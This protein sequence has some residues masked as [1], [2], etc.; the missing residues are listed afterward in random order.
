MRVAW[1]WWHKLSKLTYFNFFRQIWFL[2]IVKFA[3]FAGFEKVPHTTHQ[4]LTLS[5]T[6][7]TT[8]YFD[9]TL[10][11]SQLHL[12]NKYRE[13][14]E[15]LFS[16]LRTLNSTFTSS[17]KNSDM[18]QLSRNILITNFVRF[19]FNFLSINHCQDQSFLI[20]IFF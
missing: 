10:T 4:N 9:A 6:G 13:N 5:L 17:L 11:L 15:F 8:Y 3:K 2:P 14:T 16:S 7:Y 12:S 20:K 18:E 1:Y 19:V